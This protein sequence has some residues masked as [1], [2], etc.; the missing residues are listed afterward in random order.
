MSKRTSLQRVSLAIV[1][2]AASLGALPL[3]AQNQ[4]P[5]AGAPAPSPGG[6]VSFFRDVRPILEKHCTGCHQPSSRAGKLSVS[7]YAALK[8]GGTLG[9]GFVTGRPADSP[10]FKQ[11]S[12]KNPPMPKGGP[13]LSAHD[14]DVVRLWIEQGGKDDTPEA[15][16]PIS[17]EHPPVYSSPPVV[18]SVAYSPD[19]KLMAISGYREVLLYQADGSALLGRLVGRSQR[20]ESVAFSPDGKLLAVVG[21]TSCRFGELQLWDVATRKELKSTEIGFDV[22]YG[23]SFSPDG[24]MV[25]FG[26]AEKS[27]YLYTVPA[28]EQVLKFDNHSDWVFG[29]TFSSNSKNMVTTGRDRAIKLVE[30]ATKNFVDDINYQVYNGGYFAVAR[31]PKSDEVAVGGEEGLIRYYSIYKKQARTMNREDYNLLRTYQKMPEPIYTLAFSPD[32]SMLAAGCRN[33]EVW[34]FKTGDTAPVLQLK[35]GAGTV[36]TLAWDPVAPVLAVGGF[37]GSVILYDMP[38]GKE[39]KRFVPAPVTKPLRRASRP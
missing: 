29:T 26:G 24:K 28:C 23:V 13:A 37:D 2:A 15:K 11:I 34:V 17:P 16:D 6:K 35:P 14:V 39:S 19:G 25:A 10:L 33:G 32:G 27:A 8:S 36:H 7:S 3:A 22:L 5:F 31:N 12:G 1:C 4:A 18:T 38:A 21:G 9:P 30:I 20:V